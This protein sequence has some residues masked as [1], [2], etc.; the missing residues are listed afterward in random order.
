MCNVQ[1]MHT[2]CCIVLLKSNAKKKQAKSERSGDLPGNL[3]AVVERVESS[4]QKLSRSSR[5]KTAS[6]QP[7]QPQDYM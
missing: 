6:H 3:A 7:Q 4:R 1:Q 2:C 5:V